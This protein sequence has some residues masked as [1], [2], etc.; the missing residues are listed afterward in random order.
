MNLKAWKL[1]T[2]SNW[3]KK[4][5]NF[6]SLIKKDFKI[7]FNWAFEAHKKFDQ[8][9]LLLKVHEESNCNYRPAFR[10]VSSQFYF[11][12]VAYKGANYSL[13]N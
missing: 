2:V 10:L 12:Y 5:I 7:D 3:K 6:F 13:F 1:L 9:I 8:Y 4:S 11:S